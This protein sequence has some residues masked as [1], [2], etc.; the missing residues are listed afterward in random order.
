MGGSSAT[1]LVRTCEGNA[2]G[3]RADIL[4]AIKLLCGVVATCWLL[5]QSCPTP[6]SDA[7]RRV[8]DPLITAKS[9]PTS[10]EI[11]GHIRGDVL[12]RLVLRA[13]AGPVKHFSCK[14]SGGTTFRVDYELTAVEFRKQVAGILWE[15][16]MA[17]T[18]WLVH[19][20]NVAFVALS[21][22]LC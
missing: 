18:K 2:R 6:P 14:E 22:K 20:E 1:L 9:R 11:S 19:L 5:G 17:S 15:A 7:K 13:Y 21:G 3:G 4:D 12:E 16:A 10:W 8:S